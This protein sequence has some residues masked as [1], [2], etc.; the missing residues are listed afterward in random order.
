MR[1]VILTP[2]AVTVK[3]VFELYQDGFLNYAEAARAFEI[4]GEPEM[5]NAL[6]R[7]NDNGYEL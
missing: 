7:E 4:M 5:V 2:P 6:E 1:R 3:Q